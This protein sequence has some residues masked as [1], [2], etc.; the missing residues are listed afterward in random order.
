MD[1]KS[2]IVILLLILVLILLFSKIK[3]IF[4]RNTQDK[5]IKDDETL[6]LKETELKSEINKLK[7]QQNPEPLTPD[8]VEEFWKKH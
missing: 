5:L 6:K 2:I 1:V 4:F 7:E 3:N 8:K